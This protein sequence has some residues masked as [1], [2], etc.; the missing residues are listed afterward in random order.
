MRL[1]EQEFEVKYYLYKD[2]I[3]SIAYTY[4]HNSFDAS[5]ITQDV[6]MKYLN[7]TKSF[8]SNDDEKYWLIRVTINESKDFLRKKKKLTIVNEEELD[9]VSYDT[10]DKHNNKELQKLSILVKQLPEKYR[11]VIILHYYDSLSIKEI[12]NILNISE[13]AI[14]KRLERARNILKQEME[15]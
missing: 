9:I 11:R 15:E 8:S 7:S 10:E 1:T 6:F 2:T 4:T 12:V 14:K 5:D 3:Y 13:S